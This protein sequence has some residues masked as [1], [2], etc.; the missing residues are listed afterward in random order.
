M[1]K[2]PYRRVLL[3]GL[4]AAC[5]LNACYQSKTPDQVAKDTAQAESAATE[6]TAKVEQN[7]G[8]KVTNSQ[9]VVQDEQAADAHTRAIET[10]KVTD[11][12]ANGTHK[13]AL[14]QCESLSGEAQKS[15]RVQADTA[16]N[17]AVAQARQVRADSDPKP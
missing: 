7:A 17:T 12:Q 15:C 13:V 8:E 4:V 14:A 11:A 10:E 5:L 16:Y 2:K 6:T 1:A 9:N 3:V